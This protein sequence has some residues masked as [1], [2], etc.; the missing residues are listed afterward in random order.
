MIDNA[1]LARAAE[2]LKNRIGSLVAN[3]QTVPIQSVT[4]NGRT[5]VVETLSQQG[6]TEVTSIRLYDEKGNLITERM[7]SITVA[8]QQRLA[9]RF[10]FEVRGET[11]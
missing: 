5:I 2:D 8:D 6:I 11:R 7:P 9:F 10:E 4:R 3:N 1:Y